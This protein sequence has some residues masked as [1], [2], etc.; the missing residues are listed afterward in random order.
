M[1]VKYSNGTSDSS[2]IGEKLVN[3]F[4]INYTMYPILNTVR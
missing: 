1:Q 4:E 2:F 3:K